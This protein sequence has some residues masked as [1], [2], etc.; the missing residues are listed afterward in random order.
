MRLARR[1]D[2]REDAYHEMVW[3]PVSG[4]VVHN[5]PEPLSDHRG[6]GDAPRRGKAPAAM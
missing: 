5:N 6:R 1:V 2:R 3:D 4:E